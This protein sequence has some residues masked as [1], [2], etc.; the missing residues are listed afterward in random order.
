MKKLILAIFTLGVCA[1]AQAQNPNVYV[2]GGAA[3]GTNNVAVAATNTLT[4]FNVSDYHS[5]GVQI[6]L[7]G[8][9]AAT[10]VVTLLGY[11]SLDSTTFETTPSLSKVITLNGTNL[12]QTNFDLTLY[13]AATYKFTVANT[14]ESVG[15]TNL[16]GKYRVKAPKY[17]RN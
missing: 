3:G 7:R 1:V 5:F 10:S 12:V 8:T 2:I 14:N 17:Q 9:A 4:A 15:V 13:G 6:G 11:Q 16:S